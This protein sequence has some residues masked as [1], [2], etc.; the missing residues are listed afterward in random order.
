[1]SASTLVA[2]EGKGG[3]KNLG[4]AVGI[5]GPS[6]TN[7]QIT[8]PASIEL[9]ALR[10]GNDRGN[11]R[12]SGRDN[13]R[14]NDRRDDDR[15][16]NNRDRDDRNDRGQSNNHNNNDRHGHNNH[17]HGGSHSGQGHGQTQGHNNGSGWGPF[18]SRDQHQHYHNSSG[19][20]IGGGISI[21]IGSRPAPAPVIVVPAR[22]EARPMEMTLRAM[23][24]G[25]T[26]V[27]FAEGSNRTA[28]YS[29]SMDMHRVGRSGARVVLHNLA[30]D[31]CTP[32]AQY[33]VPF[34]ERGY[35]AACEYLR[36]V[37]VLVAG[38][39]YCVPVEQVSALR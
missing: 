18:P 7:R 23:Q 39:E 36:D 19:I 17:G 1:M 14:T 34:S 33:I 12:E 3:L 10:G 27:V 28:G 8:A 29:V 6:I 2:R 26:L 16:G 22:I 35:L 25:D 37:T 13:G 4:G 24:A 32:V 9:A 21:H 11:G 15:R 5:V 38:Q 20:V 31:A 30:P